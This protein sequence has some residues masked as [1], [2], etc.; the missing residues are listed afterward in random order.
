VNEQEWRDKAVV[1]VLGVASSHTETV[2]KAVYIS[3]LGKPYH[4]GCSIWFEQRGFTVASLYVKAAKSCF[5][6]C[7]LQIVQI[8]ES[9]TYAES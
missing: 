3:I 1:L 6:A 7:F 2:L 8:L 9:I 5:F 4:R